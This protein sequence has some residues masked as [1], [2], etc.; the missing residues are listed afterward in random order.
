MNYLYFVTVRV[1]KYMQ[2]ETEDKTKL[3]NVIADN[4]QHAVKNIEKHYE[5]KS[6]PHGT[7]YSILGTEEVETI[8][9]PNN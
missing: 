5:K 8:G 2:D 7:S 3:L 1:H 4:P 6:D 9:Y